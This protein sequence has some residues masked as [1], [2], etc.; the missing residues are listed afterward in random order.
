ME[1]TE[2][3]PDIAEMLEFSGQELNT[4]M[5]NVLR[6]LMEMVNSKHEQWVM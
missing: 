3:D 6:V 5:V 1:T 4:F 2:P